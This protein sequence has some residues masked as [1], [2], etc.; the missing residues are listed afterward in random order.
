MG[1][2]SI[3]KVSRK[4]YIAYKFNFILDNPEHCSL[5]IKDEIVNS[6]R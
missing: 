5:S 6:E 1:E 3:K 4:S 2:K